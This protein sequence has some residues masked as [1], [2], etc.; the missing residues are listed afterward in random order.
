MAQAKKQA[1]PI[2]TADGKPVKIGMK[3]YYTSKCCNDSKPYKVT[4]GTVADVDTG[5][6]R[7][8]R[9]RKPKGHEVVLSIS[10][11]GGL[12]RPEGMHDELLYATKAAAAKEAIALSAPKRAELATD[13]EERQRSYKQQVEEDKLESGYRIRRAK[14]RIDETRK[15]IDGFDKALAALKRAAK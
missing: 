14:E 8:V 4:T 11:R 1:P 6:A 5:R 2:Y 7:T 9:V 3:I 13:L 10:D 12:C 15:T